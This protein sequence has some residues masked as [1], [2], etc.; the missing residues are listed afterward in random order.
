MRTIDR[1]VFGAVV[2]TLTVLS[3]VGCV[4]S[5]EAVSG[6]EVLVGSEFASLH[7][8]R[9]GVIANHTALD[10]ELRHLVDLL[11]ATAGVKLVAVFSPEH[12]FRGVAQAGESVGSGRDPVTGVP[13]YSLYGETRAPTPTMLEGID[14]LLF[15]IQDVG[16]RAYTYLSTLSAAL[17]VAAGENIEFWVLDRPNPLGGEILEGPVLVEGAQSF[18]GAHTVPLRHGL[19]P[20]E[21]ALLVDRERDLGARIEVVRVHGWDRQDAW[22]LGAGWVAPSPNIP[23]ADTALLYAGFVLVEGTNL[24]EG[25]GT[26][27]PFQLIGAPW[28]EAPR[29]VDV[30]NSAGLSGVRFR[31]TAFEPTFSKYVGEVCQGVEVHVTDRATFRP[32]ATTFSLISTIRKLHPEL[33]EFK[34]AVFDKL[35]GTVDFREAIVSG[36]SWEDLRRTMAA[37]LRD[38]RQRREPVLLYD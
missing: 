10:S 15:D 4:R 2:L 13:I 6:L 30:L 33:F 32:V 36:R 26:T 28:L 23:T 14:V 27:R 5:R 22:P 18:V 37:D 24:S 35:A 25:R 11:A 20:G 17:E 12:G 8:K 38:F 3:L 31:A 7:G 29:V 16:V 34:E 21:F 1:L 9:V 19:T